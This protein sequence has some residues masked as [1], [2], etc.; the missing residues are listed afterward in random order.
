MRSCVDGLFHILLIKNTDCC[1]RTIFYLTK[2]VLSQRN[3]VTLE[4][5]TKEYQENIL[6]K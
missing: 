6:G 5:R 4:L 2:L 1:L 3:P